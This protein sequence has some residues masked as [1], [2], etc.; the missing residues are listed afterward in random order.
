MH[1]RQS[2][3]RRRFGDD[4]NL[5]IL[6]EFSYICKSQTLPLGLTDRPERSPV[7]L[8][9]SPSSLVKIQPACLPAP[10]KKTSRIF[11]EACPADG[12]VEFLAKR[13]M[14]G[15]GSSWNGL[16]TAVGE[17]FIPYV[18]TFWPSVKNP[19]SYVLLYQ[20]LA[21]PPGACSQ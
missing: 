18:C 14:R 21:L 16:V 15:G 6:F 3:Q 8:P 17:S 4:R 5:T 2:Q 1:L 13:G 10:V 9:P 12:M 7:P 20:G 19:V 11:C